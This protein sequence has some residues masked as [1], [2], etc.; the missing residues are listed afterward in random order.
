MEMLY[1]M[2]ARSNSRYLVLPI[3]HF[4]SENPAAKS[5]QKLGRSFKIL[6]STAGRRKL[7][8]EAGYR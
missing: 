4:V 5:G 1:C 3:K 6:Y 7:R 8:D 2:L